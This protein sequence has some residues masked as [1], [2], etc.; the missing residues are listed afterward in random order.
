MS[1]DRPDLANEPSDFWPDPGRELIILQLL[2]A[3]SP[4]LLTICRNRIAC[5]VI[6][7]PRK[8]V[9]TD[10]FV[11]YWD[12]GNPVS[13]AF[14]SSLCAISFQCVP[15]ASVYT[16][17]IGMTELKEPSGSFS[18]TR[19]KNDVRKNTSHFWKSRC[20]LYAR[21]SSDSALMH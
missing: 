13:A 8:G 12:I 11:A 9:R 18:F 15:G 17:L 3:G 4:V 21:I 2:G 6:Y 19:F 20:V 16:E 1:W 5:M 10:E 7:I 14:V